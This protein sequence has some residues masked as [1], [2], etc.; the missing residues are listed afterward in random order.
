MRELQIPNNVFEQMLKQARAEA[1]IEACGILAGR[2]C[3]VERF[4]RMTNIDQS[5][6]HFMM[7][8]KEQFNVAKDIRSAGLEMLAIYH[9]HPES[10][11]R[12]SEEDIRL[13]VTPNV[14]YVIVSLQN[15]DSP[16]IKGFFMQ[17]GSIA[18][19]TVEVR[20]GRE[21]SNL[22]VHSSLNLRNVACPLN[23]VK[24]K[25]N[26]EQMLEGQILEIVIDDG[27][28]I[29]NLP[30]AIKEEGHKILRVEDLPDNGF[31]LLIQKDGGIKDGR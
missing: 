17:D 5:S 26:L 14:V 24:T 6:D 7:E 27:E 4:Y 21:M 18:E 10:P 12:P 25:L 22:Q 9:S 19:I 3:M 2:D 31:R 23:F 30:R 15:V 28:P 29:Q 1:P 20:T 13:A 16:V 8:P 11:A